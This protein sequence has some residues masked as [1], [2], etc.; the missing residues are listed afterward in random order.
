MNRHMYEWGTS[1]GGYQGAQQAASVKVV[2]STVQKAN[3]KTTE[4]WENSPELS[5]VWN[6]ENMQG[7]ARPFLKLSL[8]K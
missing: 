5:E 3:R 2:Q 7:I 6:N 8:D 1:A 4:I